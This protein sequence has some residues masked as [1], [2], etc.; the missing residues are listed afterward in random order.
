[1]H[2]S[3]ML[4]WITVDIKPNLELALLA[5]SLVPFNTDV[6]VKAKTFL[7]FPFWVI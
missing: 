7:S 5:V 3:D 6:K 4:E 1:M 2:Q